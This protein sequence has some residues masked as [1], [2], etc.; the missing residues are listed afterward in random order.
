M[1]SDFRP[2]R[3]GG[4]VAVVGGGPGGTSCAIAL[5][6]LSR[7][8]RKEI[9]VVLYEGKIF[10]NG[11]HYNQCAGVLSPPLM[12]IFE[13]D[14]QASFPHALI[15]RE[16]DGYV[17]HSNENEIVMKA[18]GDPTYA[19]RRINLDEFLINLARSRGVEIIRSRATDLEFGRSG[20][21]VFSE[22]N[23]VIADVVVGAFGMDDGT[24]RIF[25]K[26]TAYRQ[27]KYLSSMVV[28]VH[29]GEQVM[30]RFG[31]YIHAFLPPINGIDF[32][33]VTPKLNH[34]TINIA[35]L[36][37][38]IDAMEKFLEYDPVRALLP[39]DF[40]VFSDPDLQFFKGRFPYGVSEGF[41]GHR[42]VIVGDAAGLLRPFKGKGINMG[43]RTGVRA[44]RTIM[45]VGISRHAFK[46]HYRNA[47]KDVLGDISY[48]KLMRS[49]AIIG[50]RWGLLD[51]VIESAK[52]NKI[53][54]RA[55]F[56]CVSAHKPYKK[57]ITETIIGSV[58]RK[59]VEE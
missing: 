43:I 16:I 46:I 53:W 55:L 12:S 7:E 45:K 50:A 31:N 33:A 1:D 24:A 48:G 34:L 38:V 54:E 14:L 9:R 10:E 29:P 36:D 51:R 56:D 59:R 58:R 25:E 13:N 49:L 26:T 37:T 2:L 39:L 47:W 3:E 44:A 27:P 20:V 6:N 17:L 35:G 21:M 30:K 57:I 28:K 11:T 40:D 41:F 4:V 23:N 8:L 42:Y 15:Q 22:S 19:V 32:G 5:K 52:K 18:S